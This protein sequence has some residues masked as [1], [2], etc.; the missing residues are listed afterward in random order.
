[1]GRKSEATNTSHGLLKRAHTLL[2]HK[3]PPA[4]PLS[5]HAQIPS[6]DLDRREKTGSPSPL[7]LVLGVRAI[8]DDHCLLW[9][10]LHIGLCERLQN[11]FVAVS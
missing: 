10:H 11:A 3:I 2:L 8:A 1:M 9:V 4:G 6:G 7:K 5:V